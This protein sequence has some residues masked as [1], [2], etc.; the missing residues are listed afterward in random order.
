MS[1]KNKAILE[2]AN[3]AVA[4][5]DYEKFLSF[6]TDDT[7][8]TFVGDKILKGKESVRR[9]MTAE[10]IEPPE[11]NVADLIAENHFVTAIGDLTIKD[12]D[13]KK[14]HYTY[15]DVWQFRDGKMDKLRAFVIEIEE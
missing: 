7:E 11:N 10:Y 14:S 15:C 8:W 1:E 5:G 3:A 9:W 12:K 2:E 13:G 6:C 4:Q